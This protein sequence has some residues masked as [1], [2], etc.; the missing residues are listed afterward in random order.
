[1]IIK[2]KISKVT[3]RKRAILW[4]KT[5]LGIPM[6]GAKNIIDTPNPIIGSENVTIYPGQ[7]IEEC[8][9]LPYKYETAVENGLE[10]TKEIEYDTDNTEQEE[11]NK[12]IEEAQKWYASLS[13]EDQD[14]VDIISSSR[15]IGPAMA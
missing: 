11:R 4:V 14:R 8:N 13:P 6:I 10:I 12:K 1:M 5:F 15:Q 2:Y 3:D 7:S 9:D